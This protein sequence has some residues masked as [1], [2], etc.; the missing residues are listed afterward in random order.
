MRK[1][2]DLKKH[3]LFEGCEDVYGIWRLVPLSCFY[4][5]GKLLSWN[6]FQYGSYFEQW[7]HAEGYTYTPVNG[8]HK[9]TD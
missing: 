8:K 5:G 1:N 2:W 4:L 7:L 9:K 6:D 3:S